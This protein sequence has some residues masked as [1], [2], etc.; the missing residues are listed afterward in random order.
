M[1]STFYNPADFNSNGATTSEGESSDNERAISTASDPEKMPKIVFPKLLLTKADNNDIPKPPAKADS[2]RKRS[3]DIKNNGQRSAKGSAVK[4]PKRTNSGYNVDLSTMSRE[5]ELLREEDCGL[6]F[7]NFCEFLESE[8]QANEFDFDRIDFSESRPESP[9]SRSL[10][11]LHI[12][13][14][15][16]NQHHHHPATAAGHVA[17]PQNFLNFSGVDSLSSPYPNSTPSTI[18]TAQTNNERIFNNGSDDSY[19]Y[20]I[21]RPIQS[22]NSNNLHS[23]INNP[24]HSLSMNN[25]NNNNTS[26][27]SGLSIIINPAMHQSHAN[28]NNNSA[29]NKSSSYPSSLSSSQSH[30]RFDG[31]MDEHIR[32]NSI[33]SDRH[34]SVDL[35]AYQENNITGL[36]SSSSSEQFTHHMANNFNLTMYPPP[37]SPAKSPKKRGRPRKYTH[38]NLQAGST[39]NNSNSDENN[40]ITSESVVMEVS[41][42]QVP[43]VNNSNAAAPPMLRL[44][45]NFA[46]TDI[47]HLSTQQD[48]LT[49]LMD[50]DKDSSI[51]GI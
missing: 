35:T 28:S 17:P 39:D 2:P 38:D 29:S 51:I 50:M 1:D 11:H 24:S 12:E 27:S 8:D 7:E 13:E 30:G 5:I 22:A 43:P 37:G 14:H 18:S 20:P 31:F 6:S 48:D 4:S 41:L 16:Q 45:M 36:P 44:P 46:N 23:L 47:P 33:S 42:P 34:S 3:R 32:H 25:N 21:Y 10:T 40:S 9:F 19:D 49:H 26:K 15:L